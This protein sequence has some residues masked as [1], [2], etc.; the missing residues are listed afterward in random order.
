MASYGWAIG[1]LWFLI[2]LCGAAAMLLT[3]IGT[4]RARGVAAG[5]ILVALIEVALLRHVYLKVR[6]D[7]WAG[8]GM[9]AAGA[10]ALL[11]LAGNVASVA[12]RRRRIQP[13][14][15]ADCTSVP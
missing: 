4:R 9:I 6:L 12:I 11:A 2:P 14:S 10:G 3:A 5:A 15:D 7:P 8:G 13:D 1:A